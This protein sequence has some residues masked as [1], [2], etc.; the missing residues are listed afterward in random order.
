M[1]TQQQTALEPA[2]QTVPVSPATSETIFEQI[3]ETANS[4][5]RRAFELFEKR[6][7]EFG[8][9]LE[10]WL[11]AESELLRRVPV[12]VK[13]TDD[14]LEIRAEVPG[15][16]ADELKVFVEPNRLTISGEAEQSSEE[17]SGNTLYTEW[18]SQKVFRAL[19]LPRQVKT[20]GAKATL[21]D[22]ILNLMLAKAA[23]AEGQEVE[24]T[25]A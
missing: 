10:D 2:A 4:V 9:D 7:R 16:K 20:E 8:K 11:K 18:R 12:E 19:D 6:G 5:A 24:V 23:P 14:Q 15:F 13:E 21:K 3:R 17:K 22:G 1:A 25:N